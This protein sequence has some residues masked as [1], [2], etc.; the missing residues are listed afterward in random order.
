MAPPPLP[1]AVP[2]TPWADAEAV[3]RMAAL[4]E[5]CVDPVEFELALAW[6]ARSPEPAATLAP[7]VRRAR[8]RVDSESEYIARLVIA[9]AEPAKAW[10]HF[11]VFQTHDQTQAWRVKQYRIDA[12]P[13]IVVASRRVEALT[14]NTLATSGLRCSP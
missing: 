6:L 9:A 13:T 11:N 2:V 1:E 8:K 12:V 3:D 5:E 4:L 7:L 14:R 10:A